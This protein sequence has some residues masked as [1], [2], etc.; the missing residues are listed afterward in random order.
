MIDRTTGNVLPTDLIR[1]NYPGRGAITQRVFL[2]ELYRNY[3]AIQVEVR[4]RLAG[5]LAWAVNYT[6]SVTK[7]YTAYDWYRTPEENEARNTTRSQRP[8]EPAAQS[9]NHLQLD[10]TGREPVHGRQ[11][12]R[13]GRVRR[14]AVVGH[15]DLP[16][17]HPV[18]F[19][20]QL[21]RRGAQR[22]NFDGRARRLARRHRV[23]SEP[24]AQRADIRPA[25]QNR[26][27]AAAGAAHQRGRHALSGHRGW[28][29]AGRCAH[30]PRLHQPRHDPA[31]ELPVSEAGATCRCAPR[32]TTCS[33]P[34]SI[35][36]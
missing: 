33:I 16:G 11:R 22:H 25:V 29:R 17:R 31:E 10:D 12:H 21:L 24:A 32:R 34:R 27:R 35:K 2:D 14:L 26:V 19:H 5:G 18:E 20:L 36:A 7:Q 4:R 13:Q 6:G 23:R 1:P 28:R 15:L 30:G 9:E 8:R 3:N